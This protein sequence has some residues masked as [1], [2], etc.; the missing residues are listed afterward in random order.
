MEKESEKARP[1]EMWASHRETM[2]DPP[3]QE[4]I[5]VGGGELTLVERFSCATLLGSRQ[6]GFA[7]WPYTY[8]L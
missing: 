6:L 2:A 3:G 7:S 8:Q 1:T 4:N 5:K